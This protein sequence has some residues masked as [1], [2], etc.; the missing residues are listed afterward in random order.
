MNSE[1]AIC[2][3]ALYNIGVSR[4]IASLTEQSQEAR[5]CNAFYAAARDELLTEHPWNFSRKISALP[6]STEDVF[7]GLEQLE[8]FKPVDAMGSFRV[9]PKLFAY[10]YPE[11]CLNIVRLFSPLC[12]VFE[13]HYKTRRSAAGGKIIIAALPEAWCE[14]T[15]HVT[16][17]LE[18]PPPFAEALSW[19]LATKICLSLKG[20]STGLRDNIMQYFGD[21]FSRAVMLDANENMNREHPEKFSEY[22]WCRS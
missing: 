1:I 3:R 16:D 9:S 21:A 15:Y 5:I 8:E 7:D 20:D 6:L 4:R 12:P 17:P 14:Y 18:F 22:I 19:K 11:K 13:G 10:R 2:N